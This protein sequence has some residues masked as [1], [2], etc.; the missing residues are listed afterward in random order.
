MLGPTHCLI[1]NVTSKVLYKRLHWGKCSDKALIITCEVRILQSTEDVCLKVPN[2]R[3]ER[4]KSSDFLQD[5]SKMLLNY[6]VFKDIKISVRGKLYG[7][8]KNILA[9]RSEVFAATFSHEMSE[10]INSNIK[11]EDM[12]PETAEKMLLFIYTDKVDD[13]DLKK[14]ASKLLAGA[15]IYNLKRLKEMC[16][17]SMHKNL[18]VETLLK[19]LEIADIHSIPDL[20][21]AALKFL[22][23]H[24]QG[25]K[26]QSEFKTLITKR[27][28]LMVEFIDIPDNQ[29]NLKDHENVKQIFESKLEFRM[30]TT[31][32]Q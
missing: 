25:I 29:N 26:G 1:Y 24:C 21:K 19:T 6:Q 22:A 12:E 28:S 20:M 11:I 2:I 4:L 10:K 7:A 16:I 17:L 9:T 23:A 32:T 3:L 31:D 14:L 8:H 18:N 30:D 13:L 15:E 5:M 27:P